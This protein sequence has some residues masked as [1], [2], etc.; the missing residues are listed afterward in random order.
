VNNRNIRIKLNDEWREVSVSPAD[1]LL[2]VVRDQEQ[3][4]GTKYG[5]G[6]GECGACTVHVDGQPVLSC[7]TLAVAVDGCEVRTIEGLA[8]DG[9]LDPLQEAFLD[10]AA[11]QC[12]FC[13]PGMVMT[14][15]ALLDENPHP[16]ETEVRE[17]MKGNL[18]RCTGYSS[19]VRAV[20]AAAGSP[21]Q[22]QADTVR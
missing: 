7:L 14:S 10:K 22:T 1:L 11:I 12:G 4:T 19:I 21:G 15:R 8:S 6:I 16:S 2:N 20:L 5:C 3:L 17:F 18:C 13:T 9:Q